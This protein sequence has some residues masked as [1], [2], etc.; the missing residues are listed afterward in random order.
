MT[1]YRET[2]DK[3]EIKKLNGLLV[4]YFKQGVIR[5]TDDLYK[6]KDEKEQDLIDFLLMVDGTLAETNLLT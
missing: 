3:K 2:E 5:R 4:K 1:L 6:K